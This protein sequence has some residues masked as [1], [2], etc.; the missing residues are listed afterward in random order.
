M[1]NEISFTQEQGMLLDTATDF[2]GQHSTIALV[3]SRL[4]DDQS[5]PA[6]IWQAIV[7]LGWTGITIPEAHGGL[8]LGFSEL[9]PVVEAM[10]RHLMATPLV[11]SALVAHGLKLAGSDAQKQRW[12]PQIAAGSIATLALLESDGSWVLDAPG[13][14]GEINGELLQL[15]GT[16][17]FVQDA[18]LASLILVSVVIEGQARLVLLERSMIPTAALHREVVIDDTRRCFQLTLEGITVPVEQILPQTCLVE[19]EQAAMLLLSAEMA[20]GH[21]SVL[22]LVVDY[23][24][25]RK[26]FDKLIG[27]YQALKHPTVDV[28]IGLEASRSHL[29]HAAT[30]IDG[31]DAR[32]ADIAV[33]MAKAVASEGFA[34]AG[35]R[36]IQF[37]GG[38]GFTF[39]CD[40]QLYLRRALYCQYQFGDESYQRTRLAPLLLDNLLEK[41]LLDE[42]G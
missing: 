19:L 10:G 22:N 26:Q 5:L 18:T 40:A 38:F 24:K 32:E 6:D 12:L 2:C 25:T 16:K 20:G 15:S 7:E 9:V 41:G 39:E 36:A 13:A 33:R 34:F 23:L 8:G 3:R 4:Q 31:D 28:L 42:V 30:M 35:D 21:A 29:Y 14:L 27:S 17:C 37:H 11:G 1:S